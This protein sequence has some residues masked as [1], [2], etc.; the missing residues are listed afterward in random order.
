MLPSDPAMTADE[1]SERLGHF[2]VV[3]GSPPGSLALVTDPDEA[4]MARVR[5]TPPDLLTRAPVPWPGPSAPGADMSVPF[6]LSMLQTGEWF[7]YPRLP[8]SHLR[9]TGKTGSAKTM[10]LCWN[11]LAE[12]ITRQD[13]AA[14]AADPAKGEQFLGALR[15]ALHQLVLDEQ[16]IHLFLA[17]LHKARIDR[18]NFLGRNRHTSGS[19]AAAWCSWSAGWRRPRRSSSCSAPPSRTAATGCTCWR[20]GRA[21]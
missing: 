9:V 8:I 12:G 13:Y 6:R 16:E 20:T 14:F 18:C 21:T 19:P 4:G 1:V 10:G 7:R 11:M 3:T 15:P 2:E 5:K 17:R